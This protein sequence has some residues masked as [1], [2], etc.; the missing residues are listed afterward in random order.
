[1]RL[2]GPVEARCRIDQAGRA[3]RLADRQHV[4]AGGEGDAQVAGRVAAVADIRD[5][6]PMHAI[7]YGMVAAGSVSKTR[8]TSSS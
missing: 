2:D 3:G 1:M 4:A 8:A 6:T 7:G 5:T